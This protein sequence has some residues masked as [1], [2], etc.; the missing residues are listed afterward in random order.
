MSQFLKNPTRVTLAVLVLVVIAIF[1][2]VPHAEFVQWDDDI[3]IYRNPHHGGLSWE[4]IKW[5][6]TDTQYVLYYAPLSWLTLSVL[7]EVSGLNPFGYHS[8]SLLLHLTNTILVFYLI[9][10][11]LVR[12]HENDSSDKATRITICSGLGALLWGVHPLRVEPVAWASGISYL[13]AGCFILTALLSYLRA[14]SISA[15]PVR[16]KWFWCSVLCFL[17]AII[18]Y[19]VVMAFP[20]ILVLVDIFLF[21][22]LS[23]KEEGRFRHAILLCFEKLPYALICLAVLGFTLYRRSKGTGFWMPPVT[24][25]QFGVVERLMQAFY[26]WAYYAWRPL[27]PFGLAPA[28]TNLLSVHPW[29]LPFLASA[30]LVAGITATLLLKRKNWPGMLGLWLCHLCFLVPVLGLTEHPHYTPDRYSYLVGVLLALG[31]AALIFRLW[32]VNSWRVPALA[33]SSTL[34]VVSAV[35]CARQTLVWQNSIA[36][37]EHMIRTIGNH[38]YRGDIEWRLG[39]ACLARGQNVPAEEHLRASLQ[40][41]PN[42]FQGH[43]YLAGLLARTERLD[44][45]I[46][47]YD[48]A[49]ASNPRYI[50]GLIYKAALLR[51]QGKTSDAIQA[52]RDAIRLSPDRADALEKLAWIRATNPDP[53]NRDGS[54]AVELALKACRYTQ[55]Q[56]PQAINTLAAAYAEAG[57]FELAQKTAENAAALAAKRGDRASA[58][59]NET[60]LALYRKSQPFRESSFSGSR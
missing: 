40:I 20:A 51:R 7:Y 24:L 6:F 26:V 1:A 4:R 5:M 10:F 23:G 25:D 54:E 30:V 14:N 60:M 17:A 22:R 55:F 59:L 50:G 49:V 58:E 53:A 27:F 2:T 21:Q 19:P 46:A 36:L 9:R 12:C 56:E 29:S 33:V 16:S 47:E 43:L 35:L 48:A 44:E 41:L 34:L 45:A 15:A 11:C 42:S 38:P 28:S 18:T 3:N 57:N 31:A 32:M 8:A 37:F 52:Y 39:A 13:L